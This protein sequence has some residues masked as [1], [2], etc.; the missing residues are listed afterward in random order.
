MKKDQKNKK[1]SFRVSS[2]IV[3]LLFAAPLWLAAAC[4]ADPGDRDE[5]LTETETETQSSLC[6]LFI[7]TADS[8]GGYHCF[9]WP[10]DLPPPLPN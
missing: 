7:C 5:V 4:V 6:T 8:D 9:R 3:C 1:C 2:E 10:C